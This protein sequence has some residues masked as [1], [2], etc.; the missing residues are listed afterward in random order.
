[1]EASPGLQVAVEFYAGDTTERLRGPGHWHDAAFGRRRMANHV[2][3]KAAEA[4]AEL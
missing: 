4:P 2:L 1:M 3:Q